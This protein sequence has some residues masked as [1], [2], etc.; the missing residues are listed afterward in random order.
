MKLPRIFRRSSE[1]RLLSERTKELTFDELVPNR[2][3]VAQ[4]IPRREAVVAGLVK[5]VEV[6]EVE[7]LCRFRA[8]LDDESGVPLTMVWLGRSKVSGIEVG[9]PMKA[10]GTVLKKG[11]KLVMIDP[12]YTIL[13]RKVS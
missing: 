12:S 8:V 2:T 3:S 4:C 10:R 1:D 11:D 6:A 7:G 13:N 5:S 9:T